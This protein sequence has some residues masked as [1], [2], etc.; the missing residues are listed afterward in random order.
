MIGIITTGGTIA[1]QRSIGGYAPQLGGPLEHLIAATAQSE[2]ICIRLVPLGEEVQRHR[3]AGDSSIFGPSHWVAI[4]QLVEQLAS[5]VDGVVILHGT[6]TMTH[7]ASALSFLRPF[8]TKR[9]VL[10]GAQIPVD[11][12]N[13]DVQANIRLA[14]RTARGEFGDFFGE[15][16]IAFGKRILRGNRAVKVASHATDAF[17]AHVCLS[18]IGSA[19]PPAWPHLCPDRKLEPARGFSGS[20]ISLNVTPDFHLDLFRHL[21]DAHPPDSLLINLY[22]VGSSPSPDRLALLCDRLHQHGWLCMARSQCLKG[23][24]DW[25][26]YAATE[27]FQS[28]TLIDARDMTHDAATVKLMAARHGG[29]GNEWLEM[30]IAG[31]M[32]TGDKEQE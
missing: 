27:A 14:L 22:G 7:T 10:T 9:V 15:T 13:S 16:L 2:G 4:D 30:N 17:D 29:F 23:R 31:E 21:L 11:A 32:T 18:P 24:I 1:C 20:V 12:P 3:L 6:D 26:V 8:R 19:A 25:S 5:Q 28:S